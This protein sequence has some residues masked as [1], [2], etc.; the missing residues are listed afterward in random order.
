MEPKTPTINTPNGTAPRPG[1]IDF[2][3]LNTQLDS[4]QRLMFGDEYVDNL[5]V[6]AQAELDEAEASTDRA[7]KAAAIAER[8]YELAAKCRSVQQVVITAMSIIG[9][10]LGAAILLRIACLLWLL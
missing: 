4:V 7:A 2:G 10:V 8:R 9:T 3:V 6:A 1:I 5:K